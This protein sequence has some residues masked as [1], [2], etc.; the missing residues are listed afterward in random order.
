MKII[1]D[2]NITHDNYYQDTEYVTNSMLSKISEKSPLYLQHWLQNKP[3]PSA[4]MKLGSALHCKFL[5]PELYDKQWVKAPDVDKRTKAGKEIWEKFISEHDKNQILTQTDSDTIEC[6]SQSLN[7]NK[8]IINL[9][10]NGQPESIV[11]FEDEVTGMKCKCMID[12]IIMSDVNKIII[13]LKTTNDASNNFINSIF[14]FKYHK[15]AAFYMD[16][17]GAEKYYIVAIEKSAPWAINV[18]EL[19]QES[20]FEGQA[21]YRN[22]LNLYADCKNKNFWP[23]YGHEFLGS[24]MEEKQITIF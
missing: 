21:L 4:A 11:C 23:D 24:I 18:F 9:F 15:Q 17:V 1:T 7:K 6:M 19:G 14:K 13:D 2:H 20:Y 3:E 5:T 12:Y 22:E 10:Q 16:A 8:S